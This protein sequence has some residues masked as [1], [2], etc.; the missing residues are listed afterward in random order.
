LSD[1]AA[2][3]ANFWEVPDDAVTGAWAEK[4]RLAAALRELIALCVTTG[5]SRCA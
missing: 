1:P 2:A 5:S 3:T 4:R